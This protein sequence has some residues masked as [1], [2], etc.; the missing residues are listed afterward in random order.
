MRPLV[1]SAQFQPDLVR[2]AFS[3]AGGVVRFVPARPAGSPTEDTHPGRQ[4]HQTGTRA[5]REFGRAAVSNSLAC[6]PGS[7]YAVVFGRSSH[8]PSGRWSYRR[9]LIRLNHRRSTLPFSP[10]TFSP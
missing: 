4:R 2:N 9:I 10:H 8:R 5:T 6:D 7:G 3:S 1:F